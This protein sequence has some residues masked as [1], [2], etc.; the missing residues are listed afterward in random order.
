MMILKH[1]ESKPKAGGRS[2][3]AGKIKAFIY[4]RTTDRNPTAVK[5]QKL[6]CINYCRRE[7]LAVAKVFFDVGVAA[8]TIGPGLRGLIR[9][10]RTAGCDVRHLV[11]YPTIDAGWV[12]RILAD[13]ST[14]PV[15]VADSSSSNN[16]ECSSEVYS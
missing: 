14:T 6:A 12:I 15:I 4:C 8:F 5:A 13:A 1:S 2:R 16:A 9:A 3:R 11:L 7:S 10:G